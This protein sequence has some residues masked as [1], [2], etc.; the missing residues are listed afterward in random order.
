MLTKYSN[1]FENQ[2]DL[3]QKKYIRLPEKQNDGAG[4]KFKFL[5]RHQ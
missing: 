5:Q 3:D 4:L 1:V 2:S